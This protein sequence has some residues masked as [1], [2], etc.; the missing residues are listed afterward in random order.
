M[1][2][3]MEKSMNDFTQ[4]YLLQISLDNWQTLEFSPKNNI[5]KHNLVVWKFSLE[6]EY[7]AVPVINYT[8]LIGWSS[9]SVRIIDNVVW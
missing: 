5:Q 3:D 4:I 2:K 9:L 6:T 1:S 8:I 7:N